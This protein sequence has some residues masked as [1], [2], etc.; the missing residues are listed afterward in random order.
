MKS[1]LLVVDVQRGPFEQEPQPFDADAVIE[2]INDLAARAR[3]AGVPVV[4]VQ[5]ER[6]G[7]MY[8]YGSESW[9]LERRLV[10]QEGDVILRKTTPDSF[11][12]TDLADLLAQWGVEQ[13]VICGYAT[14][15]CVDTTARRT[16]GLGFRVVLVADAHTTHDKPHATAAQIREHHN[17]TLPNMMSFAAR[18][19]AVPAADVDLVADMPPNS[20]ADEHLGA[21]ASRLPSWRRY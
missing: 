17:T 10:V 6:P 9:E 12:R 5:H 8:E 13:V 2:R 3:S 11:M 21:Q 16:A 7:T 14:E 20:A 4:F 18:I 1:A 19:Q 15:F